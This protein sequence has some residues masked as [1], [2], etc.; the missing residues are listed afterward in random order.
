MTKYITYILP[1]TSTFWLC[2]V[3]TGYN[4]LKKKSS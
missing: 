4:N 1:G 3:L 2:K